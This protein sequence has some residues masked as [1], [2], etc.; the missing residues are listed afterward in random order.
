[1]CIRDRLSRVKLDGR[2]RPT[3]SQHDKG[4]DISALIAKELG[5]EPVHAGT[6]AQLWRPLV[7]HTPYQL[8]RFG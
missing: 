5:L 1:M 8:L 2:A 7:D 3:L 6:T 4:L